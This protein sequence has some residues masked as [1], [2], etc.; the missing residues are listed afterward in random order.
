MR[1]VK[2][3]SLQFPLSS[4][5]YMAVSNRNTFKHWLS[6]NCM[7]ENVRVTLILAY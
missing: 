3:T 2:L 1:E 5:K 4:G 6:F 7:W